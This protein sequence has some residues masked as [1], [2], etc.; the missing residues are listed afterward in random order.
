MTRARS[1]RATLSPATDGARAGSG[2]VQRWT[3]SNDGGF[4][5]GRVA[6]C[7][8]VAC[9]VLVVATSAAGAGVLRGRLLLGDRPA[10]GV[11]VAA[12]PYEAPLDQARREARRLPPQP[13]VA[14]VTTGADGTFALVV[15][16]KPGSQT[17]FTARAD[18]S[19]VAAA[20]IAGVWD[21]A[22]TADLGDHV[23]SPG[24]RLA[25]KVVDAA[26]APV[27]GAEVV[28]L[29]QLDRGGDPDLEAAPCRTTTA[30]D[31][32]FRLDGA[33]VAGNTLVVDKAGLMPALERGVRAG[34]LRAPVA[35]AA[36]VAVSGHVART[37]GVSPAAGALVRLAGRVTTRWVEAAADGS[38]TVPSAPAG[39]ATVV[40]D[41]GEDGYLERPGVAL[42]PAAGK[43]LA[44]VLRTPSALVG[45]TVDAKTGRPVPR[46]RI[47]LRAPGLSRAARSA[48]D[49]TYS[50]RSLP[51]RSWQLRADEPRYVAWSHASVPVHSGETK[52]L[53][54]PLVLGATLSGRVTDEDGKPVAAATGALD[55][56]G[57][58]TPQ[59]LLR[60]LRGGEAPVFR[61][62]ADGTFAATRLAPGEGQVLTVSHPDF[63]RATVGGLALAG[64]AT[65]AGVTVTLAR[66]AA[67][68]GVVKD[69]QGQ[70]VAGAQAELSQPFT[71]GGGR[72][73]GRA[74]GAMLGQP[75]GDRKRAS[76]GANGAFSIRGVAPGE[77]VLTVKSAGYASERVDPVRV[78]ERGSIAPVEVTLAPGA[79]ISG[80][81]AFRSGMGAE[82]FRVSV[83]SPG[84]P[85]FLPAAADGPPTGPDGEFTIDGLKVG[86]SYDLQV[87]GPTGPG[88]GKRGVVAPA[89]DVAITVT[90]SG[91]ITGTAVDAASGNPLADFQVAY[92]PDRGG[93]PG[94]LLAAG[95][96]GGGAGLARPIDV[97]SDDGAFALENVPAGSWSVVVTAAGY[98]LA[99][100][101][102]VAVEEGATRAGVEVRASRG[103]LLKGHVVDARTGAAIANAAVT[104]APAGTPPGRGAVITEVTAGDVTTDADGYFEIDGVATGRQAVCASHPEYADAVQTADV[105]DDGANV[106]LAMTQGGVLAGTVLADTGQ[107]APGANVTLAAAGWGFGFAGGG[108]GGSQESVTDGAGHFRFDHLGAGRYSVTASLGSHT[109]APVQAVLQAG[110][111]QENLALQLETGVTVEGTVTGLEDAMVR[112]M[113][114]S[115]SGTDSY[116]QTTR[117]GADARFEFD[118]VPLGVVTLHGTATAPN[119]STRSSTVQVTATAAGPIVTAELAFQTGFTLS[120]RVTQAGRPVAGG[121]VFA[122]LL[123]GGGRQASATTDDTG[124]YQLDGLQEGAYS[125]AAMSAA[126][127]AATAR[128]QTIQ[129]SDDQSLDIALPSATISGQVVDAESKTPLANATVALASQ[130]GGGATGPGRRPVLTD[131]NGQFTFSGLDEGVYTLSTSRQDFQLDQRDV[132]VRDDGTDGL[133]VQ[134]KRGAGLGIKVL[135]G[136]IGGPL[137]VV[138][139]RVLDAQGAAV[140]GPS[141]VVLDSDGQGEITSLPAGSYT[142]VLAASGYAP[143]RLDGVAV[144]SAIVTV[145]VTP[146]GSVLIQSGA[147]TL[148]AA[149]AMATMASATGQ[150]AVLSLF[151]LTGRVAISEPTVQ[152]RNVSPGSYVLSLPAGAVSRTFTISEGGIATVQLP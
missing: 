104:A 150:P 71:P 110:Q 145:A 84:R 8:G 37:D 123:G 83:A 149:T 131:S 27:A 59:R 53:E 60:R 76:T 48:P 19:S 97:Q 39:P 147:K 92:A 90:G 17:L 77:Y 18:G 101:G 38:F 11:T 52:Q 3:S 85:R 108:L 124:A 109:A 122:N 41:A 58:A 93:R 82:G 98:Q 107:A 133:V 91:R 152:L 25:G 136:L 127:G 134:L 80:R 13:P 28:V 44:L 151:N 113:T 62:R 16:E 116:F 135:D 14:S 49:G 75:D 72:G 111:S 146:G 46:V 56:A 54:I 79:A 74:I 132:T 34:A 81:V 22:E 128:R 12:V 65:R 86:Q 78:P 100:T 125:V 73:A 87:L 9:A 30:A 94:M 36:G 21:A 42:P 31:G 115:A 102:G 69:G 66:G 120:G 126:A 119:G 33:S 1:S 63:E 50:F 68:T 40:A 88:D 129:L 148:A 4:A 26:G 10:A 112:G 67:V 130:G 7:G 2:A 6:L 15:P 138:T 20:A 140:L 5:L 45:R 96:A 117:V 89:A 29:P 141:P 24:G 105:G 43:P 137:R 106:S 99:R 121:M 95:A 57:A 23:L 114:V 103:V 118:N 51:P 55:Q 61:T 70:P 32:S 64:G 47:A 139:V 35:L 142:I 143:V 144:P